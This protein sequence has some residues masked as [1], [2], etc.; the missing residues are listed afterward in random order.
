MYLVKPHGRQYY[1]MKHPLP[2]MRF[3]LNK[4][5]IILCG[6]CILSSH[7]RWCS[8]SLGGE[9][10]RVTA[11]LPD[12]ISSA[13]NKLVCGGVVRRQPA[14]VTNRE[15]QRIL[16]IYHLHW[17][18]SVVVHVHYPRFSVFFSI[19]YLLRTNAHG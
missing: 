13:K 3:I 8:Y 1:L 5:N 7:R 18:H 15:E 17:V 12:E 9:I 6:Y 4:Q 19:E 11:S 2:R 14:D 10:D 16:N